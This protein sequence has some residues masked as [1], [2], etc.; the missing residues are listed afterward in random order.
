MRRVL[1]RVGVTLAWACGL[2]LLGTVG[3]LIG[4]LVLGG[5]GRLS[6]SFLTTDPLPGS[7][8]QGVIGGIRGPLVGTLLVTAIGLAIA[9]PLGV[10]TALFLT[11]Y[12]RPASLARAVDAAVDLLFG[13][14]AV[15]F[16]LLALAVFTAPWLSPLSSTVATSGQAYGRSFLVAGIVM[17]LLALPPITRATQ[18]AIEAVPRDMREASYALGK[19]HVAT[20]R[21][22]VLPGA[23]PGMATGA[24]L[25]AGRIAADTAIAFIVLGGVITFADR[26]Y[27]P[28]HWSQTVRGN[29]ATLTSYVYYTSPAGEGDERSAALSAAL[30]LILLMLLV[31]AAIAFVSRRGTWRR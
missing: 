25:G 12:R 15:V 13:I 11:E 19:G 8:Q 4:W 16:A 20:I 28:M 31:N 1:D 30:V 10:G 7:L 17:S 3:G 23:R 9:F 5:A 26:W 18:E 24:I 14:P 29:G 22:V 27:E 6:L 21:R 2:A